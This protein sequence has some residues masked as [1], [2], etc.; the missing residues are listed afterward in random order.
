MVWQRLRFFLPQQ[1]KIFHITWLWQPLLLHNATSAATQNGFETHSVWQCCCSP[2]RSCTVWMIS[3][4]YNVIQLLRQKI[5]SRCRTMWTELKGWNGE[6]SLF[7]GH[8][9]VV[10]VFRFLSVSEHDSR[11]CDASR[12]VLVLSLG[13]HYILHI[14]L[15][16]YILYHFYDLRQILQHHQP[17]QSCL[18]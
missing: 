9:T 8:I 13:K 12:S 11:C 3:F 4:F 6:F 18:I 1:P 7:P 15:L 10:S 5:R 16:Q 14:Y 17:S 2:C